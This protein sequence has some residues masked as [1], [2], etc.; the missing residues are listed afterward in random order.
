MKTVKRLQLSVFIF[1]FTWFFSQLF[2][3]FIL[4]VAAVVSWGGIAFSHVVS[5]KIAKLC[6]NYSNSF[7]YLFICLSYSNTFYVTMWKS[8]EYRDQF[9]SLWWPGKQRSTNITVVQGS[10]SLVK[11]PSTNFIRNQQ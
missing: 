4:T 7:Q 6:A 3:L 5:S 10:V 1:C 2:A 11:V 9:Y 8:K